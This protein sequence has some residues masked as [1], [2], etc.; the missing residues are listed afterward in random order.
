MQDQ[1]R[2]TCLLGDPQSVVDER[3]REVSVLW[4]R[5]QRHRRPRLHAVQLGEVSWSDHGYGPPGTADDV[6]D[7]RREDPCVVPV[8][9]DTADGLWSAGQN[10]RPVRVAETRLWRRQLQVASVAT[11]RFERRHGQSGDVVTHA[12]ND[13]QH[14]VLTERL[15]R[16]RQLL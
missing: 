11:Q 4:P 3:A 1:K 12:I 16:V 14:D 15:T 9:G 7:R 13:N 6:H 2:R 8:G 10:C 5:P